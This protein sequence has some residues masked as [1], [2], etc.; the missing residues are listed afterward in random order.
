[1][2]IFGQGE[3][4]RAFQAEAQGEQMQEGGQREPCPETA[5]L[6]CDGRM[7]RSWGSLRSQ[8]ASQEMRACVGDLDE[9]RQACVPSPQG[10]GV[11]ASVEAESGGT[12]FSP[13]SSFTSCVA[14][15]KSLY[16][17]D[18]S[19]L[20]HGIRNKHLALRDV[21]SEKY[22]WVEFFFF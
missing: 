22:C 11:G 17:S 18:P 20:F 12:G 8:W 13:S 14:L 4:G 19:F 1:M 7:R 15:G 9:E 3:V 21:C 6:V 16:L 5:W 10:Q 2:G